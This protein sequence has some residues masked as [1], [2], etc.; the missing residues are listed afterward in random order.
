MSTFESSSSFVAPVAARTSTTTTTRAAGL[1][2]KT[3][4]HRALTINT[5]PTY[6]R[7]KPYFDS[8]AAAVDSDEEEERIRVN[9]MPIVEEEY[10]YHAWESDVD[11]HHNYDNAVNITVQLGIIDA[12]RDAFQRAKK[13]AHVVEKRSRQI[14]P[15]ITILALFCMLVVFGGSVATTSSSSSTMGR[16]TL[17]PS[18][19]SMRALWT[20]PVVNEVVAGASRVDTPPSSVIGRRVARAASFTMKTAPSPASAATGGQGYQPRQPVPLSPSPIAQ[21]AD[22]VVAS[23]PSGTVSAKF[24]LLY[25]YGQ[26]QREVQKKHQ[27]PEEKQQEHEHPDDLAALFNGARV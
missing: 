23:P 22:L 15:A 13:T 19:R 7:A 12:V 11:N 25:V 6:Q 4:N 26:E 10:H 8:S 9:L 27:E 2:K 5:S 20:P 18:G 1:R 14:L 16:N 17:S 3:H 24:R 21:A